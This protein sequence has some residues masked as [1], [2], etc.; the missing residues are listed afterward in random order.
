[1][2]LSRS[3]YV[4]C[5]PWEAK[6][7]DLDIFTWQDKP[8]GYFANYWVQNFK[9]FE[10]RSPQ[11]GLTFYSVSNHI[12]VDE[13]AFVRRYRRCGHWKRR[14]VLDPALSGQSSIH[15]Q[16]LWIPP[17]CGASLPE[18][19]PASDSEMR[20]RL[21][22]LELAPPVISASERLFAGAGRQK[23]GGPAGL[24]AADRFARQVFRN[25][26]VS[27]PIF[28]DSIEN[29][30]YSRFRPRGYSRAEMRRTLA[31]G[32]VFAK[33]GRS[34]QNSVFYGTTASFTESTMTGAG[35]RY[36]EIMADTKIALAPR[37]SS[38]ET[39]RF[40]EAMRQVCAV[41]R[42]RL[43][44]TLVLRRLPRYTD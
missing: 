33:A 15:L 2:S 6:P 28:L 32:Q 26:S 23:N 31:T 39:Y 44:P 29:R 30:S 34:V 24:R 27:G 21:G 18:Q 19:S 4:V 38:V 7:F 43:S 16:D 36:T 10:N 25:A 17:W 35:A 11:S 13:T 42:D 20:Q 1:M 8:A 22:S 37:V 12:L 3:K 14:R 40:L 41:I 5:S 9:E